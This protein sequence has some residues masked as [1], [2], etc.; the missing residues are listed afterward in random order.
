MPVAQNFKV[1]GLGNGFPFCL[2]KNYDTILNNSF[3]SNND[4]AFDATRFLVSDD[5]E[6]EDAMYFYWN[7]AGFTTFNIDAH[8]EHTTTIVTEEGTTVTTSQDDASL[9][10]SMNSN[11]VAAHFGDGTRNENFPMGLSSPRFNR[12]T[13]SDFREL[14][15]EVRPNER[16]HLTFDEFPLYAQNL[17]PSA[18]LGSIHQ[19]F[20]FPC[21]KANGKFGLVY[22]LTDPGYFE[23]VNIG[24][25]DSGTAFGS[26]ITVDLTVKPALGRGSPPVTVPIKFQGIDFGDTVSGNRTTRT[27]LSI[28]GASI[29]SDFWTYRS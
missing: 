4:S 28:T 18:I 17:N 27:K 7:F 6:R 1:L 9:I 10:A 26:V 8:K 13:S 23:G 22:G 14:L 21:I 12:S 16:T 3:I 25:S 11:I 19:F 5:I 2:P 29:V 20:I 15:N 24:F